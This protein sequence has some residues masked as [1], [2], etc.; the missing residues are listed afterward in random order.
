M[1]VSSLH[2]ERFAVG[3]AVNQTAR[4]IGGAFG[5]A[6]LVVILGDPT[7]P[8]SALT[9]FHYLWWYGVATALAAGTVCLFVGPGGVPAAGAPS[10]EAEALPVP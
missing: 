2:P 5:V 3:S 6:V 1:A 4:Q 9:G 8:G 7:S 10:A